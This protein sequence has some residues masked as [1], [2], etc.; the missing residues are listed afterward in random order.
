VL[1]GGAILTGLETGPWRFLGLS[2]IGLVFLLTGAWLLF[3]LRK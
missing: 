1:L 2:T 3:R